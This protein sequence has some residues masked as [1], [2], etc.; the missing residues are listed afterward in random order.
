MKLKNGVVYLIQWQSDC[1]GP[2]ALGFVE[3]FDG[4]IFSYTG[5]DFIEESDILRAVELDEVIEALDR[6]GK[7]IDIEGAEDE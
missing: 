4:N 1:E 6:L 2:S 3:L 7:W 5:E